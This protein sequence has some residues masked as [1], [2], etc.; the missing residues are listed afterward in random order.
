M[1]RFIQLHALT[2]HPAANL[3]RDGAGRPKTLIYG[4]A[5]R[6]RISSQSQKRALR[7]SAAFARAV[8][9]AIGVRSALFARAAVERLV[10]QGLDR[11]EA[12]RRLEGLLAH[13]RIGKLKPGEAATE[14]LVHLGP[15]ELARLEVLAEALLTAEEV[16]AKQ[17]LILQPAPRAADIAMFGRMLADNPAF[18]VAA[19]V[20]VA[21]AF[22]VHRVLVEDDLFTAVDDLAPRAAPGAAF[23]GV[24][25]FAGGLFYA[26]VC[27]DA[28]RLIDNLS[29]DRT[30]AAAAV[31][32]LIRAALSEGP[33]ARQSAFA[34]HARASYAL[35]EVGEETP[36]TLGGAF[37]RP[38]GEG[39]EEAELTPAAIARLRSWREA[40]GKAYGE[41]FRQVAE[42]VVGDADGGRLGDL[43]AAARLP[44]EDPE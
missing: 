21:H 33:S 2:L 35:V 29:G 40:L 17:A 9:G 38:L 42:M 6:A 28:G 3:N 26:Y 10:A 8:G 18:N 22:T 36:R 34:S 43:L 11:A 37:E 19:A 24:S 14:Q 30:L 25:Q 1:S 44:F 41:E 16:P 15:D 4:G 13:D 5:E 31:D 20:Q 32:G 23:L 12:T 7:T 39:P 27:I